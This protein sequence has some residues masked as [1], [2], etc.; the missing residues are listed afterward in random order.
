MTLNLSKKSLKDLDS[1]IAT[2]RSLVHQAFDGVEFNAPLFATCRTAWDPESRFEEPLETLKL[3]LVAYHDHQERV[4]LAIASVLVD[5]YVTKLRSIC[6]DGVNVERGG[7]SLRVHRLPERLILTDVFEALVYVSAYFTREALQAMQEKTHPRKLFERA[8]YSAVLKNTYYF[9]FAYGLFTMLASCTNKK[10]NLG[11]DIRAVGPHHRTH[12]YLANCISRAL[13]H[14]TTIS[15]MAGRNAPLVGVGSNRCVAE[16]RS[17]VG[18]D[19]YHHVEV[20][21]LEAISH[22]Y[23]SA[24]LHESPHHQ[25]DPFYYLLMPIEAAVD[26]ARFL[27]GEQ[28]EAFVDILQRFRH[29][30]RKEIA[31]LRYPIRR[32]EGRGGSSSPRRRSSPK[33]ARPR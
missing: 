4:F 8:L 7:V 27:G 33:R 17:E 16:R 3:L 11:A 21:D 23:P 9:N 10:A 2:L 24:D 31:K 6:L 20:R 1:R 13:V 22:D 12:R 26:D 29:E 5:Y 25:H 18:M 19:M 28:N 15:I 14:A 32:G 30:L